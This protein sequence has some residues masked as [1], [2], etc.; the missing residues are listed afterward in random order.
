MNNKLIMIVL[1]VCIIIG[2]TYINCTYS[3]HNTNLPI[4]AETVNNA[5]NLPIIAETVNNA[6]NLPIIANTI[7]VGS[8]NNNSNK[9]TLSQISN[10][11]KITDFTNQCNIQMNDIVTG[12]NNAIDIF[13]Q[14]N[15]NNMAND[16][17]IKNIINSFNNLLDKYDKNTI[18]CIFKY[19]QNHAGD[20]YANEINNLCTL[21]NNK[22]QLLQL[23]KGF[24]NFLK[25]GGTRTMKKLLNKY[26]YFES[27]ICNIT[28]NENKISY[29]INSILNQMKNM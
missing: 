13:N 22:T 29:Y 12:Q 3:E 8:A 7:T 25:N 5:T 20:N 24:D 23:L 17:D 19:E 2:Y 11:A 21:N 15:T 26:Q 28:D 1:L 6:T 9:I 18:N 14:I 4:I 27:N 10:N 16:N